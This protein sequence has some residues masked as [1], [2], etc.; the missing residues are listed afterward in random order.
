MFV[1]L[2]PANVPAWDQPD[3]RVTVLTQPENAQAFR[4]LGHP[5]RNPPSSHS[6][7]EPRVEVQREG[8]R[9]TSIQ[10]QCTCGQ[11]IELACVYE[12]APASESVSSPVP[13]QAVVPR[14]EAELAVEPPAAAAPQP[15][16][17]ASTPLPAPASR[18]KRQT[19]RARREE[20]KKAQRKK[21]LI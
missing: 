15:P 17:P 12:P 10:I 2:G 20:F 16:A 19:G 4:S 13:A 3:Y 1:P 8:D 7:N 11:F 18:V 6:I 14:A 5:G 21:A 9:V